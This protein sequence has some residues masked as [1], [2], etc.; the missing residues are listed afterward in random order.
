MGC[1]RSSRVCERCVT[2]SCV[3]IFLLLLLSVAP[4]TDRERPSTPPPNHPQ[5]DHPE[6]FDH[7]G[8]HC[9][10][11]YHQGDGIQQ[12]GKGWGALGG[13]TCGE[14]AGAGGAREWGAGGMLREGWGRGAVLFRCL[15]TPYTQRGTVGVV[16]STETTITT[17][18]TTAHE[19]T[20][21]DSEVFFSRTA[22]PL[23][24]SPWG[25]AML[26]CSLITISL[27]VLKF[28][29]CQRE[30]QNRWPPLIAIEQANW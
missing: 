12:Q 26:G 10:Q 18:I 3:S 20:N 19:G 16:V 1:R 21:R 7:Q 8:D 25:F 14:R 30:G 24:S 2:V 4:R 9:T 6:G 23:K 5:D 29:A 17:H 22:D 27:V 11:D 13:G 28:C 15:S